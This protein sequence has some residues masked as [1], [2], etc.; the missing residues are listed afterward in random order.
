MAQ[1]YIQGIGLYG[2]IFVYVQRYLH[3]VIDIKYFEYGYSSVIVYETI[4]F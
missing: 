2:D 3:I 4:R 1:L